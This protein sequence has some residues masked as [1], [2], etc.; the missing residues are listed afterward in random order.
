MVRGIKKRVLILSG[1]FPDQAHPSRGI[2]ILEQAKELAKLVDVTV[3]APIASPL[4]RKKFRLIREINSYI[5]HS[6]ILEWGQV[7]QT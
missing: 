6:G 2:F 3:I 4:P 1:L 5:P 7:F